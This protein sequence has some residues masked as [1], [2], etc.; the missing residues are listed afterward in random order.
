MPRL[1]LGTKIALLSFALVF[2][3]VVI[4]GI[5]EV[6]RIVILME[7]EMGKRTMAIA[8][9]L[10]QMKSVQENVGRPGG[11]E[12]IQPIAEKIRL[13]TG[14]EYVVVLDMEGVRYSHPVK[15]RIGK[16][17]SGGD[18]GPALAN[19]EY[20][21]RAEGVLGPSVRAFTPIKVDE[22]NRQVGVVVVGILT[23]TVFAL[24]NSL[25]MEIYLTLGLGLAVGLVG[26]LFLARN[27]KRAMFSLEPEEI[28]RLLKERVA[29]FEALGEGIVAIDSSARITVMNDEARRIFR[30][31]ESVIGRPITEV[32]PGSR[33]ARVLETG[34]PEKN[35]ERIIN[36]I[37]IFSN[38]VPIRKDDKIVGAVATFRDKTEVKRLAEE[39]TGVKTFVEALRVQNHENMN[40][41]HTIAGL[42]QLERHQDALDYIFNITEEQQE[43][44]H[45]L[46][47]NIKDYSLA[48]LL[49]GKYGRAKELRAELVIDRKSRLEELPSGIDISL[50]VVI[51]GNLLENALDAVCRVKDDK[52]QVV[53]FIQG[54]K[55]G[56][57]LE[58]HDTGPGISQEIREKIFN[59]GFTT[60]GCHSRGLGLYL[61]RK[62]LDHVGG[63]VEVECPPGGR[64]VFKVSIPSQKPEVGSEKLEVGP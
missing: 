15:D 51:V 21:T 41:L 45:F 58:V 42:I 63:K 38:R 61:V 20:V 6:H 62:N 49:L 54:D 8:R 36:G 19:N 1:K 26:S 31:D 25:R 48:G 18:L 43:L 2:V 53:F 16:K 33:L 22:G 17:F 55:E 64:T 40:K 10:A 23:P 29:I 44:T 50:L 47:H 34:E 24:L 30:V 14:V 59:K 32:I 11:E 35:M 13:S 7:K 56:I 57:Y 3:A 12:I 28:A 5:I 39:L 46:T 27:V 4:G 60:K 37:T 52:R 9:T